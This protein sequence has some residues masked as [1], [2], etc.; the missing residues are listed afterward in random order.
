MIP[1]KYFHNGKI[2]DAGEC[3]FVKCD[4]GRAYFMAGR[5]LVIP[6][7]FLTKETKNEIEKLVE[8]T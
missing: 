2:V 3:Q 4:D 7:C 8:L 6:L 5:L 1:V